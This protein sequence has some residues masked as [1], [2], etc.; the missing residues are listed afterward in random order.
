MLVKVDKF[1]FLVDFIV[2]DFEADKEVQT[3]LDKP[4]LATEKTLIDVQKGEL[5]MRVNDQQV[6]I[7]VLD[8]IKNLDEIEDCN[9]ISIAD[10][11]V[12]EKLSNCCSKEEIR[13][14]NFEELEEEDITIAH[15]AWLGEKQPVRNDR[16]FEY[17]NLSNR[18]V[19]LSVLYVESS[20]VLELK[21]LPS[22]L[23]YVYL[24]NNNTLHV[25]ISSY[26]NAGQEKSL[27]EVL[28]RYKK[29]IGWTMID[30]KG[31]S[32][33]ICTQKILLEECYNNSIEQQR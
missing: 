1:I 10:I 23:K 27:M 16:P 12:T 26:L 30:I 20:S 9:F 5:T 18:E 19:K 24:G 33:S 29:V 14:A 15:I 28:G 6:T 3:I 22:H 25:I 7:N 4:F 32:P 21:M 17:P 11:T 31:I 13:A 2:L 8:A